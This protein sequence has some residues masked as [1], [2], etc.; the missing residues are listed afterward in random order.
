MYKRKREEYHSLLL[1]DD[2]PGV[3]P[4]QVDDRQQS[5]KHG[6]DDDDQGKGDTQAVE[7]LIGFVLLCVRPNVVNEDQVFLLHFRR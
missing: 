5:V 1:Q 4:H 7:Q 3:Q 6:C 2:L